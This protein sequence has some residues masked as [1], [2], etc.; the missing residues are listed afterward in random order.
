M[1]E[2]AQDSFLDACGLTGP[3]ELLVKRAGESER[4]CVF[5][6]PFVRAGREAWNDL[7]LDDA[8]VSR[9]H[10][11]LQV[12]G[13]RLY[14]IDLGSRTGTFWDGQPGRCGWLDS[15]RLLQVGP[16]EIGLANATSPTAPPWGGPTD[17]DPRETRFPDAGP[18]ATPIVAFYRGEQREARCRLTR[19]LTLVGRSAQ[20][21][22]RLVSRHVSRFHCALL[23]TLQ[24]VWAL[25]LCG[26]GSMTVNG[27]RVTWARLSDGAALCV[28][29][30]TLRLSHESEKGPARQEATA[31]AAPGFAVP[32]PVMLP[33]PAGAGERSS[34]EAAMLT[35]VLQQF[36]MMQ[37]Q[38]FDQFHQTMLMVVQLFGAL[39]R[40]QMSLVRDELDR[41]HAL[42]EELHG[43]Q[44]E[45]AGQPPAPAAPATPSPANG[46]AAGRGPAPQSRPQPASPPA[47]DPGRPQPAT[48]GRSSPIGG[49]PV[50]KPEPQPEN[51]HA[52][53]TQ[54]IASL[55]QE[56]QSRWQK[57]L[58]LVLGK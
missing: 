4:R 6:R 40:D 51:I 11:Y 58:N 53:L 42:T 36:G 45:L 21:R 18:L 38:M 19:V 9:R 34:P 48:A 10:V 50:G 28:G 32:G 29:E 27:E 22:L 35:P 12:V 56:R 16:F 33:V 8:Q 14:G 2:P 5:H 7:C 3:L 52:W 39:H 25:D 20:C 30:F 49:G 17:W 31:P 15:G 41:L 47:P 24:G 44:A 1:S 55:Q 43:L 46:A 37:Q 54:R 13:G 26:Q 57:V 23:R